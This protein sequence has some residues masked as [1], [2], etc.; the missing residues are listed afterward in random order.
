MARFARFV[1]SNISQLPSR[2][3]NSIKTSG[4][5]VMRITG[6]DSRQAEFV[7]Q[8]RCRVRDNWV[9]EAASSEFLYSTSQAWSSRL[10]LV[11]WKYCL[12]LYF[13]RA[14]VAKEVRKGRKK[15]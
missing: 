2:D 5:E 11:F 4:S 12:T 13:S 1:A 14:G 7:N 6:C 10:S 9:T 3:L 8:G 15:P